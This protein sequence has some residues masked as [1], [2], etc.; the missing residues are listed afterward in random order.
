MGPPAVQ[1]GYKE[2]LGDLSWFGH[3][4]VQEASVLLDCV[5]GL[6]L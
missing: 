6:P 5:R 1:L 4:F 3:P 2:G